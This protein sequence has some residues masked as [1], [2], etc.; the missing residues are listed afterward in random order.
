MRLLCLAPYLP[1]PDAKHAGGS[2]FHEY[3]SEMS[4]HGCEIRVLVP[5]IPSN[6]PSGVRLASGVTVELIDVPVVPTAKI[7][8]RDRLKLILEGPN[9]GLGIIDAFENAP[10]FHEAVLW[11]EVAEIHWNQMLALAPIIR[12]IRPAL[13]L[14]V[15]AQDILTQSFERAREH[16]K[17]RLKT[18]KFLAM[19]RAERHLLD[20]PDLVITMSDKDSR[21]LR[22][23]R[24]RTRSIAL[25]PPV[26]IPSTPGGPDRS[27]TVLFTGAM[28]RAENVDAALWCV[29]AIWPVV[30]AKVVDARLVIAGSD[31]PPEVRF[32]SG[33]DV[34]V[35]GTL[36]DLDTIHRDAR[37]VIVPLRL[38]A[39]VK[40]KVLKAFGHALPVVATRVGAEGIGTAAEQANIFA[41]VSDTSDQ[42]AAGLI[43]CLLD[44]DVAER[45]GRQAYEWLHS[46]DSRAAIDEIHSFYEAAISAQPPV[47]ELV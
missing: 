21:Y 13:P 25:Q 9:P 2:V 38:G 6:Q 39:G 32:L 1:D 33:D 23:M 17:G 37:V 34:V 12:R 20:S 35:T 19:R 46:H 40:V 47:R 15:L 3:L 24:V 31:P 10:V 11:A 42:L 8:F 43:R 22:G 14:G 18:M 16:G 7:G 30:K 45:T 5:N 27:R 36:T 28:W 29:Q 4:A 26:A 44:F 41:E